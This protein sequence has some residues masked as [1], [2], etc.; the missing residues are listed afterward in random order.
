MYSV[1]FKD[2]VFSEFYVK[3]VHYEHNAI[4]RWDFWN[5]LFLKPLH[6]W[7]QILLG[8][9]LSDAVIK[10]VSVLITPGSS[11]YATIFIF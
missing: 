7:E 11:A 8:Q 2:F 10:I 3:L 6:H 4:S 1:F 5:T 9:I